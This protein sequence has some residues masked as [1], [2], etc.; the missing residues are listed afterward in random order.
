MQIFEQ[1]SNHMFF[2][3]SSFKKKSENESFTVQQTRQLFL[4]CYLLFLFIL[5][6]EIV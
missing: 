1:N 3:K 2:Y 5:F 4:K 6:I